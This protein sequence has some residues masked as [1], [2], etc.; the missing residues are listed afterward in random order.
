MA[1]WSLERA[2]VIKLQSCEAKD[3]HIV[4][5]GNSVSGTSF[6][7]SALMI[8]ST[9]EPRPL[10]TLPHESACASNEEHES[11]FL[12]A[13]HDEILLSYFAAHRSYPFQV[14]SRKI[15][16]V[17]DCISS[18]ANERNQCEAADTLCQNWYN[19]AQDANRDGGGQPYNRPFM[20]QHV[21]SEIPSILGHLL[22]RAHS[23]ADLYP[24]VARYGAKDPDHTPYD[25][26]GSTNVV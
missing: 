22:A 11:L 19:M 25:M 15:T 24:V 3:P 1:A 14:A 13:D 26:M 2:N 4:F 12:A 21:L 20:L 17:E 7:Y 5:I 10:R 9:H 6:D 18:W 16:F 8:S 23:K